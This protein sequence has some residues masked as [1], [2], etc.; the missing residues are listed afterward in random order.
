MVNLDAGKTAYAVAVG[1]HHTCALVDDHVECWGIN[2]QMQLKRYHGSSQSNP[3]TVPKSSGLVEGIS[4]P[5]A[6]S[7]GY[8]HTCVITDNAM[9]CFGNRTDSPTTYNYA[10]CWN[11]NC[12]Y[13]DP[14]GWLR[15]ILNLSNKDMSLFQVMVTVTAQLQVKARLNATDFLQKIQIWN[16]TFS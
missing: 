4:K 3:V 9:N 6:I 7:A 12:W 14:A 5:R 10:P 1:M 16:M 2:D 8:N 15:R 11:T 13:G